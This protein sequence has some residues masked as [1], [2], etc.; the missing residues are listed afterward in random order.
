MGMA[1]RSEQYRTQSMSF[2]QNYGM[3]SKL[4]QTEDEALSLIAEN[5]DVRESIRVLLPSQTTY[6][7]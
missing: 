2:Y 7:L 4:T 1:D 6:S 3:L 5:S